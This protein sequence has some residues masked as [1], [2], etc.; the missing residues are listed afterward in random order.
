MR[1]RSPED[2]ILKYE[3]YATE[4]IA[5]VHCYVLIWGE[6]R[7][8]ILIQGFVWIGTKVNAGSKIRS[9]SRIASNNV[10]CILELCD[11]SSCLDLDLWED[12]LFA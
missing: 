9:R 5:I 3:T 7:D 11:L 1:S 2:R 10:N 8:P 4:T 6:P 12:H